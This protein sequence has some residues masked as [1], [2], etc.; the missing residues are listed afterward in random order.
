MRIVLLHYF[1]SGSNPVYPELATALR[2]RGHEVYVAE[3]SSDGN[4][5][6]NAADGIEMQVAAPCSA[7]EAWSKIPG[8]AGL[9]DRLHFFAFICRVR[10][11]L[12][13]LSPDVV[14]VNP[15]HM[16]G[17]IPLF[18]PRRLDRA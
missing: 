3:G 4:L 13:K 11:S 17:I 14:Q 15:L 5:V 6:Y 10:H 2:S 16:A 8:I 7:R 12:K 18:M 1:P 9:V